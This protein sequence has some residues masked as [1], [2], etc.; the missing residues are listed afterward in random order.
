MREDV[1]HPGRRRV[2]QQ[3]A[4]SAGGLVMFPWVASAHPVQHHLH[5]ETAVGLADIRAGARD[6]VPE[7]L[8]PHQLETLRIL[9]ERIVPGSTKANSGPFID[10]L[11]T[12][13]TTDD[14]RDFLQALG[15]FEQLAIGHARAP[16]T[17]LSEQQ[18]TELLTLA[19]TA[20]SSSTNQ[21]ARPL[22]PARI[23]IRDHFE[24]LKGWIAGAYYSSEPGQRE[25]GWTGAIAFAAL[26]GCDHQ[27]GHCRSWSRQRE[28]DITA[29]GRR[30]R[31]AAAGRDHH[32]LLAVH[33]YAAGVAL[34]AAG[35]VV[36]HS[37]LPVR[38]RRRGTSGRKS[39]RR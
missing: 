5:D 32:I 10:Q 29:A 33:S 8:D 28:R 35:S 39:W 37:T 6:Y 26:P 34:P 7:F 27:D 30:V 1:I 2:I 21:D 36:S 31:L 9:A 38:R 19:S 3:L 16:W 23:T 17:E 24:H 13:A 11:L 4:M 22:R 25:L 15:G 12:V 18:Q 20:K 14:Q